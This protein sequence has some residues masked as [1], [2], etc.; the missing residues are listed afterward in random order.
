M[1]TAMFLVLTQ[2]LRLLADAVIQA[3][4]KIEY[5]FDETVAVPGNYTAKLEFTDIRA[6][7]AGTEFKLSMPFTIAESRY[8]SYI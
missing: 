1:P 7:A 2:L 3:I 6:Y 4:R 8:H 5:T